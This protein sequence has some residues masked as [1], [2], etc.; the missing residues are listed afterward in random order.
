MHPA[1][2]RDAVIHRRENTWGEKRRRTLHS[3]TNVVKPFKLVGLCGDGVS[4]RVQ[5]DA[6]F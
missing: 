2:V 4:S 5:A 1:L 6:V 3:S